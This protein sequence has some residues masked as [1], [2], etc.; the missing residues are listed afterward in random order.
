VSCA[1]KLEVLDAMARRRSYPAIVERFGAHP[2]HFDSGWTP[3]KL[4][5]SDVSSQIPLDSIDPCR[6]ANAPRTTTIE[7]ELSGDRSLCLVSL[8][9][10]TLIYFRR[11]QVPPF[12]T[13]SSHTD[14]VSLNQFR[15]TTL[16]CHAFL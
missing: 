12:P 11:D 15:K 10:W 5:I 14:D 4:S 8:C 1:G 9:G 13:T 6:L 7:V 16:V 2:C 3:T